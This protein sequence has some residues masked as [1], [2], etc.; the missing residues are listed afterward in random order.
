MDYINYIKM[1]KLSK[2]LFFL[3]FLQIVFSQEKKIVLK[4]K[5]DDILCE[6]VIT[7]KKINVFTINNDE[8]KLVFSKVFTECFIEFKLP[9]NNVDFQFEVSS[10]G[11][12]V[13]ILDFS[14][15]DKDFVETTY[16]L[17]E[18]KSKATQKQIETVVVKSN[19]NKFIKVD[20]DKT[21]VQIKDNP[22]YDSGTSYDAISKLPGIMMAP[23]GGGF[24]INGKSLVVYLDGVQTNL[25]GEDLNTYLQSLPANYVEKVE[26]IENPGAAYDANTS[27]GIVN[28]ITQ[29]KGVKGING[30]MGLFYS[31]NNYDKITPSVILN[32]TY[33]KVGFNLYSGYTYY[34]SEKATTSDYGFSYFNPVQNYVRENVSTPI[35]RVF[36]F[37][38]SL[39]FNLSKK[40]KLI[41]NYVL[42]NYNIYLNNS[43]DFFNLNGASSFNLNNSTTSNDNKTFNELVGKLQNK[44]SDNA[45]FDVVLYYSNLN[46]KQSSYSEQLINNNPQYG[47]LFFDFDSSNFYVK[48]DLNSGF[49]NLDLKYNLGF[50]YDIL[51]VHNDGNYLLNQNNINDLN[52]NFNEYKKFFFNQSSFASYFDLKKKIWN[53]NLTGGLRWELVQFSS[54]LNSNRL[55]ELKY[56]NLFP[57][58]SV[59]YAVNSM[60]KLFCNY[61]RKIEIP[62][63]SYLDP[64]NFGNFDS[65]NSE[66]GNPLLRA[67]FSSN[68]RAGISFMNFF[69][70]TYN[71][72]FLRSSNF[73]YFQ[74]EPNSI[75]T[76]DSFKTF[77]TIRNTNINLS[78][79]LPLEII[80]KGVKYVQDNSSSP[81]KLNYL[82]FNI[83]YNNHDVGDYVYNFER[84]PFWFYNINA[85]FNMP[86]QTKFIAQY[87]RVSKGTYQIFDLIEPIQFFNCSITKSFFNKKLKV[88]IGLDD[89]FNTNK[90]HG[91][92]IFDNLNAYYKEKQDTR[93]YNFRITYHF[94]NSKNVK[95]ENFEIEK[96]QKEVEKEKTMI[97]TKL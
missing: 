24:S 52:A 59:N 17:M 20:A 94:G 91:F 26:I 46:K 25:R 28:I 8:K 67:N 83:A 80:S 22:V 88:L 96:E 60:L 79:P 92:S 74:V 53:I 12:E 64:N 47:K 31:K 68:Y 29:G 66:I 69:N 89:L 54:D 1:F 15:R 13:G 33:K 30:S 86:Y 71:F 21:I 49:S 5:T 73:R 90:I 23:T 34:E 56:S 48:T 51:Q 14:T 39:N 45:N 50:K 41:F 62:A 42:N 38:P 2:I 76:N 61:S 19:L 27:G 65:Y 75:L 43:G 93:M 63:Y 97:N 44:L 77:Y 84:K 16:L 18:L 78:F 70:L 87:S 11:Y 57:S 37:R 81:D 4:I 35:K 6:N 82:Y 9:E 55:N 40:S 32:G 72:S 85:Q 58:F 3:F 36:F 10:S 95:N 7:D